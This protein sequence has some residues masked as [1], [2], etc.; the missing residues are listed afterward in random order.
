MINE[1][2]VITGIKYYNGE[3]YVTV[4]R[5]FPG[6]PSTLNKVD[7]STGLLQP[8]PSC[9][10]QEVGNPFALQYVQSME[11][12]SY[13]RMWIIDASITQ[14]WAATW[15]SSNAFGGEYGSYFWDQYLRVSSGIG[16]VQVRVRICNDFLQLT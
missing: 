6:V 2:N 11:I 16:G 13:G 14:L 12:D 9:A 15:N 7:K 10:W 4:P 1:F 3:T 8:W 5:W